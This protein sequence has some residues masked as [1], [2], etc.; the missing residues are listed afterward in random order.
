MAQRVGSKIFGCLFF[1]FFTG[2]RSFQSSYENRNSEMAKILHR[3]L[4]TV[5]FPEGSTMGLFFALAV[6]LP[7]PDKSISLSY[8]FEA[9]YNL[10]NSTILEPWTE[11]KRKKRG[12]DRA[13]IYGTLANKFESLG[14]NGRGCLLRSICETSEFNLED[15]GVLGDMINIIFTPSTSQPEDLPQDIGEAE[16]I[17]HSGTCSKYHSICPV[18]LFNLIGILV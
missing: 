4:R 10:P 17:G 2:G 9:T 14:Y 7:D 18:G 3:P 16:T 6:P 12:I 8:F 1:T 11:S 5:S 13:Q 15:N